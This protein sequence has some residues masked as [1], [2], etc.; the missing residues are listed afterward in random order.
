MDIQY[1]TPKIWGP[2]FW[3]M[4]RCIANNYPELP[5]D[6]DIK[7]TRSFYSTFQFILPCI[8]CRESYVE[9]FNKTPIDSYLKNKDKLIQWVNII[10]E[11]TNKKIQL[12]NNKEITNNTIQ[13]TNAPRACTT[14]G[15]KKVTD[16][17][18]FPQPNESN[19]GP[20]KGYIGGLRK[21]LSLSSIQNK[22]LLLAFYNYIKYPHKIPT[23]NEA[24]NII[25]GYI[26]LKNGCPEG[27][28]PDY[29]TIN[30]KNLFIIEENTYI[31]TDIDTS[32]LLYHKFKEL[33][34]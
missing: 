11:D 19:S 24:K 13:T 20:N 29:F 5:T 9:H 32:L 6:D 31:L 10:Y 8:T 16:E 26:L 21:V 2:H 14:C 18:S 3:F 25:R 4:F 17:K 12:N 33:S 1:T 27:Y 34:I 28:Y 23:T 22:Y 7:Y 30:N 15:K